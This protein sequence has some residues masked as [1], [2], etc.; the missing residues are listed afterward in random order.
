MNNTFDI[1]TAT[2]QEAC[3]YAVAKIVE[4]GGRCYDKYTECCLYGD[5]DKHCAIGWLLPHDDKELMQYDDGVGNLVFNYPEK[6]PSLI[7]D[8][9]DVFRVLQ[10]LHDTKFSNSRNEH[11]E[12]LQQK[13]IDTSA[14]QYQQWVEMG[15]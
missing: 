5:R 13:G 12:Q 2:V 10:E 8:N 7:V 9:I 15:I 6:V 4:Q 14:P 11:I 3:D 1:N